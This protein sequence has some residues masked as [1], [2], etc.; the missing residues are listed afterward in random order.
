MHSLSQ[1]LIDLFWSKVNRIGPE[2]CWEWTGAK[3]PS[4]YGAF[5]WAYKL[6]FE[7][8]A[9][10]FSWE[11]HFECIPQGFVVRHKCNNR[12]CVNPNHLCLG[13][14]Q[15]NTKDRELFGNPAKGSRIGNSKLNPEIVTSIFNDPRT[16]PMIAL[17]YGVHSSMVAKIKQGKSWKHLNLLP[18][19]TRQKS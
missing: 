3:Y 8:R 16:H 14:T 1:K 13:T 17:Q 18:G 12:S 7:Q 6:G 5:G 9:H 19:R 11:L 10:R 15:D 2:E 4:G